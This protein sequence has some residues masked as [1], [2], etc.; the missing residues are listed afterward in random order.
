MHTII[1]T[2][3][4]RKPKS[5]FEVLP[6]AIHNESAEKLKLTHT[7]NYFSTDTQTLVYI[8]ITWV[9]CYQVQ[10]IL[11]QVFQGQHPEAFH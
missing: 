11:M 10:V 4:L 2:L 3:H 8:R 6:N 1:L 7:L 9:A 5:R